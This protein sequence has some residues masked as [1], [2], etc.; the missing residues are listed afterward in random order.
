MLQELLSEETRRLAPT[1]IL[2]DRLSG[3]TDL[4]TTIEGNAVLRRAGTVLRADRIDYYQPDDLLKAR[5]NVHLNRLGNVYEGPQAQIKVD[6][7]DGFILEP[8]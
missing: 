7:K 3:R 2:G 4:E 1:F 5:G 6:A 8:T